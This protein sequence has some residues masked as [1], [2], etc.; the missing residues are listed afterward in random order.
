MY[1]KTKS[2][3]TKKKKQIE[4][5]KQTQKGINI[6]AKGPKGQFLWIDCWNTFTN[7]V[8]TMYDKYISITRN[9]WAKVALDKH[10]QSVRLEEIY[11]KYYS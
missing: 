8:K 3:S 6:F 7:T 5:A 1:Q 2:L 11:N 9:V 10:K 4:A